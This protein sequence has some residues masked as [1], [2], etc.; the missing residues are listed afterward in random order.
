MEIFLRPIF[1]V[2]LV[3]PV[4]T[5]KICALLTDGSPAVIS[6]SQKYKQ[7]FVKLQ[8]LQVAP[9]VSCRSQ[10]S[11]RLI[12]IPSFKTIS[13]AIHKES[14]ILYVHLMTSGV[15]KPVILPRYSVYIGHSDLD[16]NFHRGPVRICKHVNFELCCYYGS[17][18]C[19][20]RGAETCFFATQLAEYRSQ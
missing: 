11:F 6:G 15:L 3:L 10:T 7:K 12:S 2:N 16:F 13:P 18:L 4:L 19:P 20:V 14:G 9:P 17:D 5:V 1:M 8:M